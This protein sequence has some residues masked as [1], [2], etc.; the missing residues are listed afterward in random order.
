LLV[1]ALNGLEDGSLVAVPQDESKVTLAPILER[2]HG[3]IDWTWSAQ[4]IARRLRAFHPWPGS[5][6]CSPEGKV[7]KLFPLPTVLDLTAPPGTFLGLRDGLLCV[8]CGEGA[9]GV[10]E[11]QIEGRCRV[12][13]TEFLHGA[14]WPEGLRL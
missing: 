3:R 11:V 14:R 4:T 10:P 6:T 1:T 9:L 5:F 7:L 12:S 13:A 8:A 2:D